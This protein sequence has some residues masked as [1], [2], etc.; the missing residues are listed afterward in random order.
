M[1][2]GLYWTCRVEKATV[3]SNADQR[4]GTT[5]SYSH[6]H[7]CLKVT[8]CALTITVETQF[9]VNTY[10]IDKDDILVWVG[11]AWEPFASENDGAELISRNVIGR[12]LWDF[13]TDETTIFLYKEMLSKV[14]SGH[15]VHFSFRCDSPTV[16]RFLEMH[17][18]KASR[19]SVQFQTV[20]NLV[21]ERTFQKLY[22]RP[23][24]PR[25]EIVVTCSWCK[26][27]EID[28]EVWVEVEAAADILGLFD[29]DRT[30]QLEHR[31]CP[32]CYQ[33]AQKSL[34]ASE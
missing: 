23:N 7:C 21:E 34:G 31:V 15:A 11:S 12:N 9:K 28:K 30:P 33:K 4:G 18:T 16:R 32:T 1:R 3:R 10:I 19:D 26:K 14:R 6:V 22:Q 24:N 2:L 25:A 8:H 13:V 27:I 5:S 29:L 20:I 17:I